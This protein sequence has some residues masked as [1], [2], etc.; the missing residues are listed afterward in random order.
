L[1]ISDAWTN[2]KAE[3]KEVYTTNV[4]NFIEVKKDF[5]DKPTKQ[6]M[7]EPNDFEGNPD[8]VRAWC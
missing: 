6:R 4:Q 3:T 5:A 2:L 8:E 1:F 7:K